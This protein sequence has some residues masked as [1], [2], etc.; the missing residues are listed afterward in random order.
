MANRCDACSLCHY[1]YYY[2]YYCIAS[3]GCHAFSRSASFA[4]SLGG[5]S[6]KRCRSR[7]LIC[8]GLFSSIFFSPTSKNILCLLLVI[9]YHTSHFLPS[10]FD[11]CCF[12]GGGNEAGGSGASGCQYLSVLV[13]GSRGGGSGYGYQDPKYIVVVVKRW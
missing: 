2:Y 5:N 3:G 8:K 10:L 11:C 7:S 13:G 1:H 9:P 4:Y 12:C 6:S